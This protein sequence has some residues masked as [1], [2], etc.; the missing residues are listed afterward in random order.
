MTLSL[1][2]ER[3][4]SIYHVLLAAAELQTNLTC[5]HAFFHE[6]ISGG[7]G[8]NK[9]DPDLTHF[10]PLVFLEI[11]EACMSFYRFLSMLEFLTDNSRETSP[12][13]THLLYA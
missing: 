7:T 8:R 4:R 13:Y 2:A 6:I 9:A 10:R 3:V 1:T 5:A 12:I 11:L